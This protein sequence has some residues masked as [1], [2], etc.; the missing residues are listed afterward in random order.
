MQEE[1]KGREKNDNKIFMPFILSDNKL[2]QK[3]TLH[4]NLFSFS[5]VFVCVIRTTV[6]R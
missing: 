4:I 1:K 2:K 6:K 3:K 5:F